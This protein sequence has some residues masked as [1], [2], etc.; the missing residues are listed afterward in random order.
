VSGNIVSAGGPSVVETGAEVGVGVGN[1]PQESNI[2][3]IVRVRIKVNILFNFITASEM[4]P[5]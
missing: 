4:L 2:M 3:Q 5:G 1:R